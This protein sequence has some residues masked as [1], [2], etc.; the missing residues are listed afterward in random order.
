MAKKLAVY[1][2]KNCDTM[3]KA[4]HWLDSRKIAYDFHDYKKEGADKALIAAAMAQLGWEDVINR[5]GTTWRALPEATRDKMNPASALK[6][7]LDNP[8]LIKRPLVF[9]GKHYSVGFDADTFKKS[10]A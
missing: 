1:G 9:D 8:S 4:F 6:A 10:F 2:I 7:A 3:K 5:K